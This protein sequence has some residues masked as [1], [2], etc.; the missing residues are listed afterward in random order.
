ML[1]TETVEQAICLLDEGS[2]YICITQETGMTREDAEVVARAYDGGE[3]EQLHREIALADVL[4]LATAR[5][6]SGD[7]LD[8]GT[9]GNVLRGIAMLIPHL[10]ET[11]CHCCHKG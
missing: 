2:T 9:V 4:A 3:I 8:E 11:R 1:T 6:R 7:G 5:L 10:R